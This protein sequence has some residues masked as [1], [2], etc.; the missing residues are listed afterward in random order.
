VADMTAH[1]VYGRYDNEGRYLGGP[2]DCEHRTV[3]SH[4]AWCLTCMEWCYPDAMCARCQLATP[5]VTVRVRDEALL[6]AATQ[7][8]VDE[9]YSWDL[10]RPDGAWAVLGDPWRFAE[11][12][13]EA[14]L[15]VLEEET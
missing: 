15:D 7:A 5:R 4:R 8:V 11:H 1:D 2:G 3:G 10:I 14:V 13:A 12:V 6:H 9:M